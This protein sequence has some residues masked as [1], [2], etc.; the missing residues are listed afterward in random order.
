MEK[1]YTYEFELTLDVFFRF[2]TLCVYFK[3]LIAKDFPG[4]TA[5]SSL[6]GVRIELPIT[7]PE[8]DYLNICW[9]EPGRASEI[10]RYYSLG[11]HP[12]PVTMSFWKK[13]F[14]FLSARGARSISCHFRN[15]HGCP[16]ALASVPTHAILDMAIYLGSDDLLH[17]WTD[18]LLRHMTYSNIPDVLIAIAQFSQTKSCD[19][20]H[21]TLASAIARSRI[22]LRSSVE[23][24]Y[25]TNKD[26]YD[27]IS[28][29][30]IQYPSPN[31]SAPIQ[32]RS[33]FTRPFQTCVMRGYLMNLL[34]TLD[35]NS[36]AFRCPEC[37]ICHN[38]IRSREWVGFD[39]MPC[40]NAQV[41]ETCRTTAILLNDG[42]C[43]FCGELPDFS[44]ESVMDLP[45]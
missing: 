8:Y 3:H 44:S 27:M 41:H 28:H 14:E 4:L 43:F 31:P 18:R 33:V 6:K 45:E 32:K 25:L 1:L 29:K 40:C 2:Q 19:D 35:P 13:A 38:P 5:T 10:A 20:M 26:I 17:E 7:N 11:Y 23:Y 42:K 36:L 15:C 22:L 21:P 30:V 24:N 39:H 16:C 9:R 37:L 12:F 34:F